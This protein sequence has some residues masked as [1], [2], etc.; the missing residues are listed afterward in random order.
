VIHTVGNLDSL[1]VSLSPPRNHDSKAAFA[2]SLTVGPSSPYQNETN[3]RTHD[4][5]LRGNF[6]A[7]LGNL[8]A[9]SGSKLVLK[10]K[11]E[12]ALYFAKGK[13]LILVNVPA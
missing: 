13:N 5:L 3:A 10:C 8:A 6:S 11:K 2:R 7:G 9:L 1:I 4:L 12:F